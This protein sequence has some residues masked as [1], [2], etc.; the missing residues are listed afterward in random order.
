VLSDSQNGIH[1]SRGTERESH[2]VFVCSELQ[3]N[4]SKAVL[5]GDA[6]TAR[7]FP[8]LVDIVYISLLV[9]EKSPT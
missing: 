4:V 2:L 7:I 9:K 3:Q 6:T 5:P 8:L 1:H